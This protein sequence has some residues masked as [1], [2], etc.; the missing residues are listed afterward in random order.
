MIEIKEEDKNNAS[1]TALKDTISPW[2]VDVK[3]T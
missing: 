2:K 3:V 1:P